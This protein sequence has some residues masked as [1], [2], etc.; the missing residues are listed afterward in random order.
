VRYDERGNGLSDRD[1]EDLSFE[2]FVSDLE[3]VVDAAGVEHFDL[4][5]ISQGAAVGIAYAVRHPGRV[6]RMVLVGG[7][8]TGWARRGSP[9]EIARRE[10]MITLT[11]VGWG[12]ANPAFR[13][14]FTSLYFPE[15]T[16]EQADSFNELQRVSA[17]PEA[18]ERLQRVL[19]AVDVV[20]LLG[21]VRAPTLVFHS[22][23]DAVV[24]FE[25]G[26]RL[27]ARIPQARFVPLE[28]NNHLLLEHEPAWRRMVTRAEEFLASAPAPAVQA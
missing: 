14:M 25:E 22:R 11:H 5:G 2:A 20:E 23:G 6:R 26:R 21:D 24:P 3:T 12:Q 28:S 4:L 15:A 10:A 1:V 27:A 18:A 8:A 16:Q 13:Q 7:Y 19:G 9:D 17:S